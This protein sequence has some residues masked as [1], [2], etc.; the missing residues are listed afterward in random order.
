M[1]LLLLLPLAAIL[2][3]LGQNPVPTDGS[4][5]AVLNYSWFKTKIGAQQQTSSGNSPAAAMIPQNRNFE[6][7]RRANTPPGE[8]DPNLDTIDG[9]S[10][11]MD[12][13]V[14]EARTSKPTT[15]GFEYNVK[16]QNLSGKT[17]TAIIWE[18]QFKE[19]LTPS[20]ITGRQF[21][22]GVSIKPSKAQ[23]FR[24]M[25]AKGPSEVISAASLGNKSK[26][27]FQESVLINFIEYSDGS[28]WQRSGWDSEAAR[29][30]FDS[31]VVKDKV[32]SNCY[33]L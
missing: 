10:A 7:N 4:Q 32:S 2:V 15:E 21:L 27:L 14:E 20:N 28:V 25:T 17:I 8:R 18:Y 19:S 29:K 24:V 9:R 5:I 1:K 11:A 16:L 6:R 22:C 33:G 13:S 30:A 12:R 31:R 26:D 23:D 3:A